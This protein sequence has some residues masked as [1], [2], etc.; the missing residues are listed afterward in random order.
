MLQPSAFHAIDN[1]QTAEENQTSLSCDGQIHCSH[2]SGVQF[3][4][5]ISKIE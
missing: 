1:L 2:L 3:T 4:V 5:D